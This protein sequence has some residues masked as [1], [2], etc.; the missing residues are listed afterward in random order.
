MYEVV[1][2]PLDNLITSKYSDYIRGSIPGEGRE[3]TSSQRADYTTKV[4]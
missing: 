2:Q 3:L 4:W 1:F